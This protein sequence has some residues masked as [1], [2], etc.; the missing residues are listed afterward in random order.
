MHVVVD[1]SPLLQHAQ[2]GICLPAR[3]EALHRFQWS[4]HAEKKERDGNNAPP[5][6]LV[7]IQAVLQR[8]PAY[9]IPIVVALEKISSLH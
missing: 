1:I 5:V 4:V 7:G 8:G 6:Q 2:L 3:A 9:E